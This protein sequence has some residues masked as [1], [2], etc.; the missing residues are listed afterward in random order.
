M[1]SEVI[2]YLFRRF[3]DEGDTA[4]DAVSRIFEI[5][6]GVISALILDPLNN[7]VHLISNNGSLYFLEAGHT[8]TVA[9]ESFPIT[10]LFGESAKQVF[11]CKT[12][13]YQFDTSEMAIDDQILKERGYLL[14]EFSF[15]TQRQKLLQYKEKPALQ[16]CT[17]CILPETMPFIE[18]DENGVCNYCL[19]I[20]K[21]YRS[22]SV[23]WKIYWL[24]IVATTQ[25]I[26]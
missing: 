14:P 5:C 17:R 11:G 13:E 20:A 26:A 21:M 1:D 12:I 3:Q 8:V 2:P 4:A 25:E 16:R 19:I 24:L 15:S 6:E 7:K 23:C 10:S 18:F 9:S 22:Q